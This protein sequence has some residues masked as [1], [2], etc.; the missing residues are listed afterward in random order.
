MLAE[1]TIG[2]LCPATFDENQ[3]EDAAA[4]QLTYQ[5]AETLCPIPHAMIKRSCS[6]TPIV[7]NIIDQNTDDEDDFHFTLKKSID[8][9]KYSHLFRLKPKLT[10]V[11]YTMW[12]SVTL[13]ALKTISLH[14]YLTPSFQPPTET[15]T[16]TR[17]HPVRW[18][19]ANGFVASVLSTT[20]SE[21]VQNKI[22]HLYRASDMWMEARRLYANTTPTDWTLTITALVTTCYTDGKDINAHIKKMQS[23]RR[24]LI[25]MQHDIDNE[26]FACYLCISML[27][28]WNYVFAALPD[29]YT[30]AEVERRIQD[31]YGIR[32]SQSATFSAFQAS[33]SNKTKSGRSRTPIPGQ[34]YCT[35]CKILGHRIEGCYSKGKQKERKEEKK[36]EKAEK[37]QGRE[38]PKPKAKKK[39]NQ[40]V[41]SSSDDD[42]NDSNDNH[43]LDL[44]LSAYLTSSHSHSRFGW[45]LDGGST[46]HICTERTAFATFMPAHNTIQGIVKN[47]PKLEV[48]GMGTVLILVSVKGKPD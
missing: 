17:H 22:G 3:D 9:L 21:E 13:H 1:D 20:M 2:I 40:A 34:P 16:Q 27:S 11:N 19:K 10:G 36:E 29:H 32:S 25:M 35:N 30:S 43:R 24:D 44:S 46:N 47:G 33:Q 5:P 15:T 18:D 23:H 31:E 48:L 28:T 14:V 8:P 7:D 26:L 4:K 38:K 41:A 45:I 42:N 37:E 39:A 6:L 12:A